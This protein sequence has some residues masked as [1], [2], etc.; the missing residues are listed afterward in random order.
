[1]RVLSNGAGILRIVLLF[2]FRDQEMCN[3][4]LIDM[5]S[6]IYLPCRVNKMVSGGII[7]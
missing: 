5:K 3:R 4:I 1:M 6:L 2:G 7:H